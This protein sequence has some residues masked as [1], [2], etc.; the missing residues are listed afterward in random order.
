MI[1]WIIQPYEVYQKILDERYFYC[2]P[3]EV[4]LVAF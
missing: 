2:D 4:V 1:V 3:S